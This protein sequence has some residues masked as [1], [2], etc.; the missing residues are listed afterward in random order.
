MLHD[1]RVS[2]ELRLGAALALSD[3]DAEKTGAVRIAADKAP[4]RTLRV[5]LSRIAVGEPA[6]EAIEEALAAAPLDA[7]VRRSEL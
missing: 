1:P 5:A 2:P 7:G 4:S 6:D 3:G